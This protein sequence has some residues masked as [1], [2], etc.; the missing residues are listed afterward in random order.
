MRNLRWQ[1]VIVGVAL[2][3]IAILLVTQRTVDSEGPAATVG[4]VYS[5]GLIGQFGRLNPL[6]DTYNQPDRDINRLIFSRL[7][8]F[9]TR[10]NPLPD[11][12]E[13]W[14]VS[15]SGEVYNITLR[16]GALWHDGEPVTTA[17]VTFTID[18]MRD[19]AMPIPAD[20]RALW[21]A[22][23]VI[24]FDDRNMQFRLPEPFS[25][26][27]DYLSFGIVPEHILA[28][29]SAEEII[30]S[31]FNLAPVGSGPYQFDQ[32]LAENDLIQGV[33]LR[34]FDNY[35]FDRAF[36]TQVAFRFY[37]TQEDALEAYRQGEIFGIGRVSGDV[38]QDALGEPSLNIFSG[39]LP[40]LT[41]ILFN[42]DNPS[43]SFFQEVAVRRAL[44]Q[45]LNR[46]KIIGRL[47]NGQGVVA[48]GPILPGTWAYYD[49]QERI[50]YNQVEA[51]RNLK[52]EGYIIPSEGG[53]TRVKDTILLSFDLVHPDTELHTRI[54]EMIKADWAELGVSVNLVAVDYVTL[55][56]DYLDPREY[57][58]A[59]IDLNLT[60]LPD[61]DPYPFW[62][63][64]EATGGQNYSRWDDRRASEYLERARVSVLRATRERLYRNFQVHFSRELPALPLFYLVY[65]YAVDAQVQGVQMG[66]I[67]DP[68]DRFLYITHWALVLR[69]PIADTTASTET[70][71]Q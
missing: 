33:V 67:F 48:D 29:Q 28:G 43:V 13:A 45:G 10:G 32:L 15:V 9:D 56:K 38:L 1:L 54:A 64:A 31:E 35:Y 11:L 69:G 5:E 22:V 8:N 14:G 62:H 47:L 3:A 60:G 27:L 63:Q 41:L 71:Q 58:A 66:P 52:S 23:E 53:N 44:L 57:E 59:L 24:V 6:L 30:N 36:I 4:G 65:N 12:A 16:A 40:Q 25:P 21:D 39:R 7:I 51:E 61:P 19:A 34:A 18:L 46:E 37:P 20:I 17:D 2:V 50:D 55:Q 49:E 26:F 70:P 68:S 42:L